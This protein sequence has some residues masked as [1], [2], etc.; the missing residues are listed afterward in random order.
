[1]ASWFLFGAMNENKLSV[2]P[3]KDDIIVACDKGIETT[4]NF[5]LEPD[6]IIGDFDSL[7]FVPQRKNVIALPTMK[8][9]TDIAYAIKFAIKNGAKTIYIYGCLGGNQD[10]NFAN[11]QLSLY[12]AKRGIRGIFFGDGFE[13]T[14]I[15]NE[16][17][18]LNTQ[19]GERISVFSVGG[20]S[21]GVNLK[22]MKY[23]LCDATLYSD[24]P[25]GVS[26]EAMGEIAEISV[27]EGNLTVIYQPKQ[28]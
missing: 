27:K 9:D 11:I 17:L 2:A 21:F 10:H 6:Y 20:T 22:G 13:I 23:P 15:T 28:S 1:M 24:F 7:G 19:K 8:D 12:M 18:T 16:K 3:K 25:I 5:G 26:N 14:T 4:E